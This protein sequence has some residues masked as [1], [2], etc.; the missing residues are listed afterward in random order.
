MARARTS[1]PDPR[2]GTPQGIAEFLNEAFET[3]DPALIVRKIGVVARSKGMSEM[4][5]KTNR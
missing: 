2:F 5:R 1:A 4:C 3:D